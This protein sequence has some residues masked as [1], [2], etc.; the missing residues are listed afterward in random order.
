MRSCKDGRLA[1]CA[2]WQEPQLGRRRRL[3][4]AY[5]LY[6][7]AINAL[8]R[9]DDADARRRFQ[10]ANEFLFPSALRITQRIV[11]PGEH[12]PRLQAGN[13]SVASMGLPK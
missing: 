9:G 8:E 6:D 2:A 10:Q 1:T 4:E 13:L 5:A 7:R 3:E 12:D 11:P